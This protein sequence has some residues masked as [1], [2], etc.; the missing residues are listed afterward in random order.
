MIAAARLIDG[1]HAPRHVAREAQL[2]Y[3]SGM[4]PGIARRRAGRGFMYLAADG[5]PVN[6]RAELE[7]IRRLGIPPAWTDVWICPRADGHLQAT[8]YDAKGRK[9]YRYHEQWRQV[10]NCTKFDKLL[11]FGRILPM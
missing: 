5:A 10:S 1:L 11:H 6:D 7:R 2:F 4:V 8:G 9:Q 3:V